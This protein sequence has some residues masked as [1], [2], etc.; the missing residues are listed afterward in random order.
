[1]TRRWRARR[2]RLRRWRSG[3]EGGSHCRG[4][5]GGGGSVAG[6]GRGGGGGVPQGGGSGALRLAAGRACA[7]G[8]ATHGGPSTT[9]VEPGPTRGAAAKLAPLAGP[10]GG[11]YARRTARSCGMQRR[12][13]GGHGGAGRGARVPEGARDCGGGCATHGGPS[14]TGVEPGPPR[15]AAANWLRWRVGEWRQDDLSAHDW[16]ILHILYQHQHIVRC[17]TVQRQNSAGERGIFIRPNGKGGAGAHH[18]IPLAP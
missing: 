7:G 13:G 4:G 6:G 18:S 9:G 15:G 1:M 14:A 10:T 11:G 3:G 2:W 16:P 17:D 12:S 5:E 8:C